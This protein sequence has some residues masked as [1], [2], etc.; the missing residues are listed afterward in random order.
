MHGGFIPTGELHLASLASFDLLT[1]SC[2]AKAFERLWWIKA[3]W[4]RYTQSF[5]AITSMQSRI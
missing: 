5:T 1:R 3:D 2:M 4:G